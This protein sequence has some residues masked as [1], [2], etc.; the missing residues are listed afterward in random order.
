MTGR[1]GDVNGDGIFDSADL[2]I[3]SQAG[4]FEDS[5]DGNSTFAEGDWNGDGDFT[6]DDLVFAFTLGG[7]TARPV[8]AVTPLLVSLDSAHTD[9]EAKRAL[10][11]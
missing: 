4:E 2:A 8:A 3:V 7:F 1:P 5:I 11:V 10:V 9:E 6:T